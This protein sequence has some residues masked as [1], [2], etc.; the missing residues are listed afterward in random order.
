[1]DQVKHYVSI[2]DLSQFKKSR[3]AAT[4]AFQ[5]IFQRSINEERNFNG[6]LCLLDYSK[7]ELN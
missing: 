6:L 2:L 1:M 3:F 5:P 4:F 7:N